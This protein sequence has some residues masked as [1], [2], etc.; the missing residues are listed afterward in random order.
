MD[1]LVDWN[2]TQIPVACSAGGTLLL[3]DAYAGL[4]RP[5]DAAWP[6]PA[7]VMKLGESGGPHPFAPELRA[8]VS[9]TLGHYCAL[10]SIN[11]EDAI[12]W[13][14][15]GPLMLAP[16]PTRAAFLNWLCQTLGLPWYQNTRCA[17][18]LWRRIPHPQKPA[19][20]GPELDALVDG[21]Q[22]VVFVEAKW[23]SPEGTGQGPQGTATQM[24][25][26]REFFERWGAAL[27]GGRGM[28]VL[29]PRAQRPARHRRGTRRA[30]DCG[31]LDHVGDARQL[32]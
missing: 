28:V 20:P 30:R 5:K 27:H 17:I 32:R 22:V 13:S 21:N 31:E 24:Q 16:E 26:R 2:G 12:T 8:K 11:S 25:L 14:F 4:M 15:F 29:G 18:D 10:Q 9:A 7:L 3:C 19:A 1:N 23:S 6:P